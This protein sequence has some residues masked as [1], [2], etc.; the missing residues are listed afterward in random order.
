MGFPGGSAGKESACN[1]G[2]LGSIPGLGRSPGE[3][4]GYPLQY[5]WASQVAQQV[6]NPPAIRG[7]IPG[8]RRS[9]GERKGYPLLY[10]DL[11][12]SMD[13]IV[14]GVTKRWTQLSAFHFSLLHHKLRGFPSDLDSKESA[15][16]MGDL[17]LSPE[18]GRSPGD[19]NDNPLQYSC[20]DNSVDRR[21]W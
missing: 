9:P 15:C 16:N 8:F 14:L 20:L 2:D 12:N 17:S 5:S 7:S 11:K 13:C 18:L 10:S 1:A 19:R 4:I 3:G 21:A 6:K